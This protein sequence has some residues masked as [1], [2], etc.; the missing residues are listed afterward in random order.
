MNTVLRSL[1]ERRRRRKG[2]DGVKSPNT[3]KSAVLRDFSLQK[4]PEALTSQSLK[5]EDE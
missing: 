1:S 5:Q 4:R 3:R 2:G